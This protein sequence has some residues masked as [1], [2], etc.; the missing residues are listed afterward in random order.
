M[1]LPGEITTST[2]PEGRVPKEIPM[3]LL[4][5]HGNHHGVEH[6]AEIYLDI[7]SVC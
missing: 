2:L 1:D 6:V 5:F 3:D 4:S 7:S